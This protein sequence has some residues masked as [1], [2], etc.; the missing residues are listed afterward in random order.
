AAVASGASA[1]ARLERRPCFLRPPRPRRIAQRGRRIDRPG[2]RRAP[3]R[4][5]AGP[6]DSR[7]PVGIHG[8]SAAAGG[9]GCEEEPD[10]QYPRSRPAA[11]RGGAAHPGTG[12]A[13][14]PRRG[15][16]CGDQGGTAGPGVAARRRQRVNDEE[17]LR[18]LGYRQELHRGL[19]AFSNYALSLSIICI[20]AG[21][22]TSFHV[23]LCS[24]GGAAIGLGWPLA[25]LFS[26]VVA[27]T[28]GQVA[29]ACPTAGGLYH[30]ANWLGGRWWGWVTAWFNLAGLITVLAAINVGTFE[31]AMSSLG[32]RLGLDPKEWGSGKVIVQ[33]LFV[34]GL[35]V[36]QAIINHRGIRLTA[37]L[38]DFSGWWILIVAALL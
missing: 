6:G 13:D 7:E 20:L 11:G 35:V 27:L 3:D 4:R 38:T 31:F 5:T 17:Q 12:R 21:G 37:R 1:R 19:G 34:L 25:C 8:L 36:A 30:W 23:G 24:V 29:S 26:L 33:T 16:R 28:M 18:Q 32:K 15:E 2:R 22:V 9:H 14:A 10:L